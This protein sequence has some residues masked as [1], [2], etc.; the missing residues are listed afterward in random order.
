METPS[1][2]WTPLSP[3]DFLSDTPP[4]ASLQAI[5]QHTLPLLLAALEHL[6]DT[7]GWDAERLHLFG[8][9]QAGS[10]ALE[11][12]RVFSVRPE[13]KGKRLGSVTSICGPILSTPALNQSLAL[14]TPTLYF[15]RQSDSAQKQLLKRTF[16]EDG[17]TIAVCP[18]PE[19]AMPRGAEEWTHVMRFWSGVLARDDW[20][21]G[22][23]GA[24]GEV[25]EVV[26]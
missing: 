7:C 26:P 19:G 22:A 20:M 11:L 1:F 13:G 6:T 3:S 23:G 21:R 12:A 15:T 4:S 8:W 16:K 24:D 10:I 9:G 25:Y 2:T 5:T 14:P 17:L 18:G